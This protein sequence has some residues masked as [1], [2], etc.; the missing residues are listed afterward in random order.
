M[1]APYLINF[2]WLVDLLCLV[3]VP[4]T[5]ILIG[6]LWRRRARRR[7]RSSRVFLPVMVLLAIL[8]AGAYLYGKY[9]G[10]RQ[11]EVRRVTLAFDT[12][13]Q[14]FDGYRIVQLSDIHAGSMDS[15]FLRRVVDSVNAVRPDLIV[16]T[17]DMQNAIPQELEPLLPILKRLKAADGICSVMG[18]HD[19]GDYSFLD[20]REKLNN[21]GRLMGFQIDMDWHI[22]NNSRRFIR[23]GDQRIVI[24]GMENDGEGRFPEL[25]NVQQALEGANRNDF[26][27]MLE[28]DPTSW[29]RKILRHCHAQLT[30][31]GHTHGGQ[32]A[33][34]GWTP[35]S[36]RYRECNGVYWMGDRCINVT[37]G[38][39]GAIPVRLGVTPEIVVITLKKK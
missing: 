25:G 22:M 24:G 27:V 37:K 5:F 13:P 9:V 19:Y 16:I 1:I 28:H 38:I 14:A 36:L 15:L 33:F 32:I 23:R 30:L 8:S 10:S 11:L 39:G 3:V 34:F 29:R 26:V 17:G 7:Q 4:L 6:C 20:E 35:A 18:N 31:S 12:L 21:R 2:P